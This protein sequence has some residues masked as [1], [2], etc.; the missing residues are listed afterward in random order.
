MGKIE[1]FRLT[2]Q[3]HHRTS[4]RLAVRRL[5][6]FCTVSFVAMTH[7]DPLGFDDLDLD[8]GLIDPRISPD[9][10][11]ALVVVRRRS[12]LSYTSTRPPD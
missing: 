1:T 12:W 5:V 3:S 9:G 7:A 8:L 11:R 10:N 2:R 6:I 4:R